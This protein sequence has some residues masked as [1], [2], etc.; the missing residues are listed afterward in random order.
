MKWWQ[1]AHGCAAG[2]NP[3]LDRTGRY[4]DVNQNGPVWFLAGTFGEGYV[5]QRA[6]R[7][8]FGKAILFP[9]INYEMNELEDPSIRTGSDLIE[10]VSRDIDDIVVKTAF[11]DG[12]QTPIYRV[13]SDPPLFELNIPSD[14]CMGVSEGLTTAAADGYWV[15]LK[16]LGIGKHHIYFHGSCANG[17]R[18]AAAVYQLI[19]KI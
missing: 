11:V 14:N 12:K 8:P 13:R 9:V 7:I 15:F 16:P 18:T 4:A 17:A 2:T 10:H 1:W 19:V 3:V 6:C 5:P